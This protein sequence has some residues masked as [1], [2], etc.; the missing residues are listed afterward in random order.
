MAE[1]LVRALAEAGPVEVHAPGWAREIYAGIASKSVDEP[2]AGELG[3]LLK[4]SFGAAWRWRGLSRRIGVAHGGRGW[5]LTEPL[6]LRLGEHRREEYR[7]VGEA[8]GVRVDRAPRYDRPGVVPAGLPAGYVVLNPWSPSSTVRWPGFRE[9]ATR[10]RD[11]KVPVVFVCGPGEADAVSALADGFPLL[12]NLPFPALGA[13]LRAARA[14]VSNDSGVAHFAAACGARL[15]VVHG[16]T[17]PALTG[18]GEPIVGSPVW[19]GP[20]Y[21]KWCPLGLRCLRQIGADEVLDRVLT[22]LRVVPLTR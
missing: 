3:V 2:P 15:L 8:L 6:P 14:V 17:D 16:S 13:L 9:L 22:P 7:R 5:L 21:R 4:P 11:A 18:S 20:C 19:C 10:L 12:P 1:P